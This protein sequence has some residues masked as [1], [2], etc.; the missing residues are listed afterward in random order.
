MNKNEIRTN[1]GGLYIPK[2]RESSEEGKE[3]RTITG[4][5]VVFGQE[6]EILCEWDGCY[7]EIIMPGAI[8]EEDLKGWDIQMTIWHNRER[9]LARWRE[10]EGSLKLGV[11]DSG[12]WY[13]F[14]APKTPD[15]ETALELV[16]RG[17]LVGASFTYWTDEKLC[18]YEKGDD[19]CLKRLVDRIQFC[20][21]MTLASDPAYVQ[22]T[23]EARELDEK[24]RELCCKEC[25][26][27]CGDNCDD[28]DD[29]DEDCCK[30][31]CDKKRQEFERLI[32]NLRTLI[33]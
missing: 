28:C 7:R 16:K 29:D 2:L 24:M 20:N 18:R 13:Q 10:G 22:T 4:Y 12:V 25:K 31:E 1:T 3:S 32:D 26:K 21:E 11:D 27:E 23:A 19:G 6:S 33:I 15:G 30:A 8:T 14:E 17:D 5:A 9:L